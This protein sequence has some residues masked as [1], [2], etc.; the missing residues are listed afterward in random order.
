MN[1]AIHVI[2]FSRFSETYDNDDEG[3]PEVNNYGVAPDFLCG[4][5][6][7]LPG[8]VLE[9]AQPPFTNKAEFHFVNMGSDGTTQAST[10]RS[11]KTATTRSWRRSTPG[12]TSACRST[13]SERVSWTGTVSIDLGSADDERGA[14]YTTQNGA[15]INFLIWRDHSWWQRPDSAH[16]ARILNMTYGTDEQDAMGDAASTPQRLL[17]GTILNSPDDGVVEITNPFLKTKDHAR[18]EG[19]G[20]PDAHFA[21]RIGDRVEDRGEQAGNHNEVWVDSDWDGPNEGDFYHPFRRSPR[22]WRASPT[23]A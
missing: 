13:T 17:N 7:Y 4:Y 3:Y 14:V 10:S 16:G 23:E 6:A 21:D 1:S 18:H 20:L 22:R 5:G 2:Q 9:A 15:Q 11:T 8:W 19:R 12:C